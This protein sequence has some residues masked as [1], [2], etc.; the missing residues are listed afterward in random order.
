[1]T[2]YQVSRGSI[3]CGVVVRGDGVIQEAA[4]ILGKWAVSGG[5]P[6]QPE[7]LIKVGFKVKEVKS[8]DATK[9]S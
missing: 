1:M 3:C 4:A 6:W 5:M 7:K 9:P 2:L 8:N